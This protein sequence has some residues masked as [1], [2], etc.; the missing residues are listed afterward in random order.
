M[1][2]LLETEDIIVIHKTNDQ[3]PELC[4][5]EGLFAYWGTAGQLVDVALAVCRS[6]I[7]ISKQGLSVWDRCRLISGNI[8][9][10]HGQKLIDIDLELIQS[11]W[12]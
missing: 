10:F 6:R 4:D 5:Y 9:E 11:N 1:A 2:D 3:V 8:S 7:Y 12:V